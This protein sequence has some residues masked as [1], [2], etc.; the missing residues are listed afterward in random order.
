[1]DHVDLDRDVID[2]CRIHFDWGA[3]WDDNRVHLHIEDGATFVQNK[4]GFYDVIIQDSSDPYTWD[5]NSG[6]K[7]YLPSETLYTL[8]IF[9]MFST[10]LLKMEYLISNLRHST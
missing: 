3:C 5:K 8:I 1:V 4:T 10:R 9:V 6:E 7:V 2:I